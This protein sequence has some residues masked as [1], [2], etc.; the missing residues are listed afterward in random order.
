[1]HSLLDKVGKKIRQLNMLT[2]ETK[3]RRN[4]SYV[5]NTQSKKDIIKNARSYEIELE[6]FLQE[7]Y[8]K[9][10]PL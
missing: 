4:R 2:K 10:A 1:M 6:V 7:R 5:R 8:Q 9:G 3:G